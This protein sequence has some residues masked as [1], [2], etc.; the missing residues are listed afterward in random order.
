VKR[1]TV[2]TT[3]VTI[4]HKIAMVINCYYGYTEPLRI[5]RIPHVLAIKNNHLRVS[6]FKKVIISLMTV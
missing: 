3:T 2:T 4:V 6:A 1:D 5:R